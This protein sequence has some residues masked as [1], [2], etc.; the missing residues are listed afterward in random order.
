[1]KSYLGKTSDN[2][3]IELW[4]SL[5]VEKDSL[6]STSFFNLELSS[7]KTL[8]YMHFCYQTIS[9]QNLPTRYFVEILED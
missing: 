4:K 3:T 6:K 5:I 1:M 8:N 7:M 9:Y 2:A